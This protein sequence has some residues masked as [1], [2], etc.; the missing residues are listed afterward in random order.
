[1]N[2]PTRASISAAKLPHITALFWVLKILATTLGETGGDSLSLSLN[3]GYAAATAFFFVV[4]AVCLSAQL[5]VRRFHPALYWAAIVSTTTMGTTLSDFINRGPGDSIGTSGGLGY[6]WGMTVMCSGL[7]IVFLIWRATGLSFDV[8]KITT[9]RA[10]LLYWTAILLSNTLGTALGD[11]LA[12]ALHLGFWPSAALIAAIMV[13]IM[14]AHYTTKISGVLLFWMGFILTRPLGTTVGNFL[15]KSHAKGG[16]ALGN[17]GTTF[18]LLGM[19]IIGIG[20]SYYLLR[21]TAARDTADPETETV[22]ETVEHERQPD[23]ATS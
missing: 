17:Y 2:Q 5:R 22:P 4:L 9:R 11:F 6:E 14:V 8:E 7:V 23:G 12:D 15:S 13:V 19:V 1:M 3:L 10:E 18:A 16:L 20:Y 21:S